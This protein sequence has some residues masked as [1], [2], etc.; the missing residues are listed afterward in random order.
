[1]KLGPY[2][3]R[4]LYAYQED[5]CTKEQEME[6]YADDTGG[7][8]KKKDTQTRKNDKHKE[9]QTRK[10][11]KQT[12]NNDE[13]ERKRERP[14]RKK[15]E[16][17]RKSHR[18]ER[19][20]RKKDSLSWVKGATTDRTTDATCALMTS[21]KIFFFENFSRPNFDFNFLSLQN[22]PKTAKTFK[23][24]NV[25]Y[26]FHFLCI[27]GRMKT[28]YITLQGS[29]LGPQSIALTTGPTSSPKTE[30]TKS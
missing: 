4:S 24:L 21:R 26:P 20:V 14:A 16:K 23:I 1:M 8:D 9:T 3:A 5:S 17:E 22:F 18:Q 12:I 2:H 10:K 29:E 27:G 30:A 13:Q 7:K 25:S 19:K 15:D 11:D 28:R 6:W